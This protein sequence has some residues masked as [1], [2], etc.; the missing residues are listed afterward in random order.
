MTFEKVDSKLKIVR[1][2][3]K[4]FTEKIDYTL[5]S[6][7]LINKTIE[8]IDLSFSNPTIILLEGKLYYHVKCPNCK[9]MYIKE[10][11]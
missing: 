7:K 2:Q 4:I 6:E 5:S 1:C 8:S 11:K 9:T 3:C 10:N